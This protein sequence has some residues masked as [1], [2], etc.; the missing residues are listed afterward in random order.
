MRKKMAKEYFEKLNT[1]VENLDIKNAISGEIEIKHFFSGAALYINKTLCV[2]WSPA[3]LAFKLG[4]NESELLI[5]SGKA[6]P[7]KYFP[8]GHIKKGYA[9]F[10]NPKESK[11]NKW[12]KHF[13]KAAEQANI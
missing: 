4:E 7:L 8:K 9:A 11:P 1:L 5:N 6:V 13:V 2:S 12:K 3:G 10:E